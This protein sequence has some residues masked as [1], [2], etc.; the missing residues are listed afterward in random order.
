VSDNTTKDSYP[1]LSYYT[2]CGKYTTKKQQ[3]LS[4]TIPYA[5]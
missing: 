1:V 2:T 4:L 5:Q 3:Q